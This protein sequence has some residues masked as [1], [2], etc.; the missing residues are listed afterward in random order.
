MPKPKRSASLQTY[1]DHF[2]YSL[3]ALEAD[4][5]TNDLMVIVAPGLERIE[6]TEAQV[7]QAWRAV[8]RARAI[9]Y[10]VDV[11]LDALLLRL[12]VAAR[13]DEATSPELKI[14]ALLFATKTPSEMG[15]P[16]GKG[17]DRELADAELVIKAFDLLPEGAAAAR[18]ILEELRATVAEGRTAFN[19]LIAALDAMVLVRRTV[20]TVKRDSWAL[21]DRLEGKLQD[22]FPDQPK[23][24]ASFFVPADVSTPKVDEEPDEDDT[25]VEPAPAEPTEPVPA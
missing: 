17:F 23:L 18:A 9:L 11:A 4:K 7:K 1:D 12:G 13:L 5:R 2:F 15:R 24:V 25:G 21:L 10:K 16:T 14:L 3:C 6:A 19:A 22:R 20:A 8:L